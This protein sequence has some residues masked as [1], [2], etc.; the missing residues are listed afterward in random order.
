MFYLKLVADSMSLRPTSF[1]LVF[2][3][4]TLKKN[5]LRFL[6]KT[7]AAEAAARAAAATIPASAVA[8]VSAAGAS[9]AGSSTVGSSTSR[10][11]AT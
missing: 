6:E 10:D 1:R 5:Y 9:A 7:T 11:G 4:K 8:G 3:G 2:A